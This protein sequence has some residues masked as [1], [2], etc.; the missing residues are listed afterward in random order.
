MNTIIIIPV[1]QIW[2]F[3]EGPTKSKPFQLI[4]IYPI[5]TPITPKSAVEAPAF[6]PDGAQTKL[7]ILPEIPE[8]R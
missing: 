7:K 5:I 2:H 6:I 4:I 3:I 1:H 8:T